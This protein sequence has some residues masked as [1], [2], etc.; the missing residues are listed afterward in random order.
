MRPPASSLSLSVD[1]C[2]RGRLRRAHERRANVYDRA[3][4]RRTL[5][6]RPTLIKRVTDATTNTMRVQTMHFG[7]SSARKC[8]CTNARAKEKFNLS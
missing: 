3:H 5:V 4:S 2:A 7:W 6:V 1:T 8:K